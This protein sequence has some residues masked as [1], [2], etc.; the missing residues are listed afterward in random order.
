[1]SKT[2]SKNRYTQ[3]MEWR[4][5]MNI[6]VGKRRNKRSGKPKQSRMEYMAKQGR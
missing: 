4:E 2:S 6:S 5:S 3:L 1:M